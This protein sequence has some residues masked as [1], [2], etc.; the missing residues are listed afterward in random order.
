MSPGGIKFLYSPCTPIRLSI[1]PE[2][3]KNS[4]VCINLMMCIFFDHFSKQMRQ[5][6][7]E[8]GTADEIP[9]ELILL[10]AFSASQSEQCIKGQNYRWELALSAREQKLPFHSTLTT[11]RAS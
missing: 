11:E 5:I 1:I 9:L 3:C 8:M 6:S 2:D 10:Q 4:L 7:L